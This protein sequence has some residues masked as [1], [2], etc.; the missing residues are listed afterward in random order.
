MCIHC[1][2]CKGGVG[3][4]GLGCARIAVA[5]RPRHNFWLF[6]ICPLGDLHHAGTGTMANGFRHHR[7]AGACRVRLQRRLALVRGV[8]PAR[9]RTHWLSGPERTVGA[10]KEGEDGRQGLPATSRR[11]RAAGG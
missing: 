7:I 8:V 4:Q 1:L 11:A 10:F 2:G 5:R 9:L 3:R 6:A